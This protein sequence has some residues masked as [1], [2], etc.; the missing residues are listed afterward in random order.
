[1]SAPLLPPR[2]WDGVPGGLLP[3]LLSVPREDDSGRERHSLLWPADTPLPRVG[4]T[5]T[6]KTYRSV[7]DGPTRVITWQHLVLRIEWETTPGHGSATHPMLT[8]LVL[9]LSEG[10]E[11]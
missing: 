9:V 2:G 6:R 11:L 3:L 5:L 4:D 8:A 10:D 7:R 1:M